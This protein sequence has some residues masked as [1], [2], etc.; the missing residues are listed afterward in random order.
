MHSVRNSEGKSSYELRFVITS[1]TVSGPFYF[2]IEP[3]IVGTRKDKS[4]LIGAEGGMVGIGMTL[5]AESFSSF[6]LSVLS[7]E[8]LIR[9]EKA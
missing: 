7:R 5:K 4:S 9:L 2:H 1:K 3:K 8:M 6:S